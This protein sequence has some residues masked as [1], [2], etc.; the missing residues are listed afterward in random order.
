MFYCKENSEKTS[1]GVYL[2]REQGLLM[3]TFFHPK[4][5]FLKSRF[6]FLM[7]DRFLYNISDILVEN[8]IKVLFF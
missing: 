4:E 5:I 1:E 6:G 7:Y 8:M 2:F 3:E